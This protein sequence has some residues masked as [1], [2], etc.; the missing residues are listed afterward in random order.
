MEDRLNVLAVY[1]DVARLASFDAAPAGHPDPYRSWTLVTTQVIFA[2][3]SF[4][5][6]TLE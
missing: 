4:Q 3:V 6:S 1:T 2:L 5:W